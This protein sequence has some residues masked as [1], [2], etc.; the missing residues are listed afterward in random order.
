M[1]YFG[2]VCVCEMLDWNNHAEV[3][4]LFPATYVAWTNASKEKLLRCNGAI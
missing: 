1:R 2:E 4:I 3:S